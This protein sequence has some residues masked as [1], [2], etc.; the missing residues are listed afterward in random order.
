MRK[1]QMTCEQCNDR[2]AVFAVSGRL[3]CIKCQSDALFEEVVRRVGWQVREALT[4]G[5][6]QAIQQRK[7]R[8]AVERESAK[9]AGGAGGAA[10]KKNPL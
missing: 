3:L 4:E 1:N 2:P 7:N 8:K 5:I 6:K 10:P 9:D